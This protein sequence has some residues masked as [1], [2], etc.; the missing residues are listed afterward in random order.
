MPGPAPPQRVVVVGG[1]QFGAT[2]VQAL[3]EGPYKGRGDLITIVDRGAEPP[4]VDAAIS[5]Y[6]KIV[7]ADYSDPIY[8]K[9]ALEAIAAWRTPQWSDFFH[10]CGVLVGSATSDPQI[11]YVRAAHKLNVDSKDGKVSALERGRKIQGLYKK[12]VVSGEHEG[13]EAYINYVGGWAATRAVIVHLINQARHQGVKIV[14][15]EGAS[16]LTSSSPSSAKPVVKG[17][18]L[19]DGRTLEADVTVI[20]AGSWTPKI[21]PE[22]STNCLSTGQT[23][24]TILLDEEMQKKYK[25]MPVSFFVDT[26]FYCFPPTADGILKLAIHDRGWLAPS[27][28]YPSLPRTTLSRGFEKQ[29][30]PASALAALK[31]QMRRVHPELAELL[32]TRLYQTR[33]CWYSDRESG[34]FLYDWHPD[35]ASNSLF[36][37]A[38]GS[39]HAAKFIPST[40]HWIVSAMQGTLDPQLARLW[41]FYGDKSRL[42]KS[43]GEGPIVRRDLDTGKVAVVKMADA[44][45]VQIK[46]KL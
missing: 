37:A 15:G 35:Y 22:L 36:V 27:G 18:R 11:G 7:R 29:E 5:D 10:E 25:D 34:D 4:A 16:L 40:G 8:Q 14:H 6:N 41:S 26:G 39:G 2:T 42:D 12:P 3:L 13:D 28:N 32:E 38:G 30:I 20:A 21:L 44:E 33:L 43:R 31:V 24:C 17:I 46:A 23:V 19:T 1:G 9:L 45:R